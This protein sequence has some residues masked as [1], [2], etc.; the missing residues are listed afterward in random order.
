M[1]DTSK[2]KD[3]NDVKSDLN[4]AF[5]K[6]HE[7]KYKIFDIK[8]RKG[9]SNEKRELTEH[10]LRIRIH[11]TENIYGLIRNFVFFE[12][13]AYFEIGWFYNIIL[14][15]T[16]GK[17]DSVTY[18]VSKHGNSKIEKSFYAVKK[19]TLDQLKLDQLSNNRR[20]RSASFIYDSACEP[21]QNGDY[22]DYP[23]SKKQLIDISYS[24]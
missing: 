14:I 23:R 3:V 13:G 19:S 6:C 17:V 21:R 8:E 7:V 11:R 22:G 10:E 15:K 18:Q 9:I 24:L 5:R 16:C 12:E 20:K 2:L 1:A 4:G